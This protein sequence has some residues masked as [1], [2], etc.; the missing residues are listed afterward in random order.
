MDKPLMPKATAIWLIEHTFLTFE[1]IANFC[2]LHLLEVQGIAD[3]EV[4]KGIIGVDPIIGGQLTAEE[5]AKCEKNPALRLSLS[6]S[7]RKVIKEQESR[8]KNAKYTPIVKRQ[9]KPDA[10]AWLLKHCPELNDAQLM[11][12]IG[13]TKHTIQAV[14]DKTHWNAQNIRPRDPVLLALCTQ[15]ELDKL[16][17]AAKEKAT[18][19]VSDQREETLRKLEI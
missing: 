17:L 18:Q 12:L 13:T 4:A 2:D 8:K 3:G 6:E 14:R 16:Y 10:I 11:K 5:V 19:R 9:D 1:Q 7:A 15:T